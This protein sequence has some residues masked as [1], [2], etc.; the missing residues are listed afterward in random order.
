MFLDLE[1]KNLL[2]QGSLFSRFTHEYTSAYASDKVGLS[3]D[4]KNILVEHCNDPDHTDWFFDRFWKHCYIVNIGFGGAP[5]SC[6]REYKLAVNNNDLVSLARAS[7]YLMDVG[8]VFH[9]TFSGQTLHIPY[10]IALDEHVDEL[11]SLINIGTIQPIVVDNVDDAVVNLAVST[12]ARQ[13]TVFEY[14]G[15]NDFEGLI[16]ETI[17]NLSEVIAYTAGLYN[18]FID[19]VAN[20]VTYEIPYE[21]GFNPLIIISLI[22]SMPFAFVYFLKETKK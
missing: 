4:D 1:I 12:N 16:P 14:L 20:G 2:K 21:A 22:I 15:N 11:F 8:C 7:H 5:F 18:K 17:S 10:E 6:D 3:D 13:S 19:D 9:T